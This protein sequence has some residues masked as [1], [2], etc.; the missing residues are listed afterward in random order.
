MWY[1]TWESENKRPT[2]QLHALPAPRPPRPPANERSTHL[3]LRP[4]TRPSKIA[5]A[6]LHPLGIRLSPLLIHGINNR[7]ENELER[8]RSEKLRF[9]LDKNEPARLRLNARREECVPT[10]STGN[11]QSYYGTNLP[12]C[13]RFCVFNPH[14]ATT[15]STANQPG[16][17]ATGSG[18]RTS[19]GGCGGIPPILGRQRSLSHGQAPLS[20]TLSRSPP[21]VRHRIALGAPVP[22]S[23]Y[24]VGGGGSLLGYPVAPNLPS[25]NPT[26][27]PGTPITEGVPLHSI[28]GCGVLPLPPGTPSQRASQ[29]KAVDHAL[30][31]ERSRIKDL[32]AKEKDMGADALRI[33]LKRERQHS[34]RL[35][36]DL[37]ALWSSAVQS[38]ANSEI[39]DE[40]R[41]NALMRRLEKVQREKGKI[42]VELE[43]EEEMV[44]QSSR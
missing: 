6:T 41:M 3:L 42:I 16:A 21:H 40:S 23:Q 26:T 11:H 43:R 39:E 9:R 14:K 18:A 32:E 19:A 29:K 15:M 28:P 44:S 12:F 7:K 20:S 30:E 10:C 13:G 38:Q 5:P 27:P 37:A 24:R 4:T 2:E 33:Q 34:T 31:A 1:P 36:C 17:T 22:T 35:A 25:L 8:R